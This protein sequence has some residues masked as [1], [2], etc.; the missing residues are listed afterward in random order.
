[1]TKTKQIEQVLCTIVCHALPDLPEAL[2]CQCCERICR[3]PR[4]LVRQ[5]AEADADERRLAPRTE[6]FRY[7]DLEEVDVPASDQVE[8]RG[9]LFAVAIPFRNGNYF[10]IG[11]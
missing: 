6:P 10:P 11:R 8:A 4:I 3:L 5:R 9:S 7:P 1:M 2:P